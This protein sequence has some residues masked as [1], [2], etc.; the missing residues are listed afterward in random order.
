MSDEFLIQMDASGTIVLPEELR[1]DFPAGATFSVQR[2]NDTIVLTR[3]IPQE[4]TLVL[5]TPLSE[6]IT[7]PAEVMHRP[8]IRHMLSYMAMCET[9]YG[10]TSDE[11]HQRY[12]NGTLTRDGYLAY[13]AT[14][15]QTLHT[16]HLAT[17]TAWLDALDAI[18]ET[19]H[20][21]DF[22]DSL[23]AVQEAIETPELDLLHT[24][25]L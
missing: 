13:W 12:T 5:E 15:Y 7:L 25:L 10:I 22:G 3:Q 6:Q 19:A 24:G 23:P 14:C 4:R 20:T 2:A 21:I 8:G 17:D 9:R 18:A 11:F 1:A 16:P